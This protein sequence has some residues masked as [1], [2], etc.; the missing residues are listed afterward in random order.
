MWMCDVELQM[1]AQLEAMKQ[2]GIPAEDT[3]RSVFIN[4][5][6]KETTMSTT[7][8][9][10]T[11]LTAAAKDL[12]DTYGREPG[13]LEVLEHMEQ[14]RIREEGR[15]IR[16][17]FTPG[18]TLYCYRCEGCAVGD[19]VVT[20]PNNYSNR[21]QLLQVKKLGRPPVFRTSDAQVRSAHRV[22][23]EIALGLDRRGC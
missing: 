17:Q 2:L 13:L 23:Q 10:L 19:W 16:V 11:D 1:I 9:D 4:R 8:I 20:P 6:K 3:I 21:P 18:G 15:Y 12:R 14:Q 7:Q 5:N 22:P